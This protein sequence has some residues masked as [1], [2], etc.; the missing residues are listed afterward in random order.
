MPAAENEIDANF[1]NLIHQLA[2][3]SRDDAG[4]DRREDRREPFH[5]T[6]RI[7][8]RR[9][10]G[11][12]EESEFIEVRCQDL[13]RRGFSFLMTSKPKFESL[14][15]AFGT[16]PNVIYVAAA[17]THCDDV[18]VVAGDSGG[19]AGSR[20]APSARPATPMVLV[21]C[22]FTERLHR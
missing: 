17:I 16:P 19:R 4:A 2:V 21:G 8:L 6:Q 18:M 13:T 9:G 5:A 15:A 12:P 3:S 22:R 20:G 7:A 1:Y 14:V 10:P 11:V